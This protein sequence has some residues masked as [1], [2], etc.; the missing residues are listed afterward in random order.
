MTAD[1]GT[2]SRT[3]P[4]TIASATPPAWAAGSMLLRP[5]PPMRSMTESPDV[6]GRHAGEEAERGRALPPAG[7]GERLERELV[8]DGRDEDPGPEGEDEAERPRWT[9]RQRAT[10]PP[11]TSDEAANAPHRNASSTAAPPARRPRSAVSPPR[12]TPRA[13]WPRPRRR[14]WCGSARRRRPGRPRVPCRCTASEVMT[15]SAEVPGVTFSRTSLMKPSSMPMWV[16]DPASAPVAAPTA[17]PSSGTKKIRPNRKPQ[18]AP[19]SAPAPVRSLRCRVFGFFLPS[20]QLTMAASCDRDQLLAP[21]A[22]RACR[23]RPPRP[24]RC[25][26]SRP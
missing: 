26:T 21:A 19:P 8:G 12:R 22:A 9:G 6:E 1:S 11:I 24:R 3:I 15:K 13:A 16:S 7:L 2:P 18:K 4:S 23:A 20:G 17:R 25:G 14:G 10:A 5:S